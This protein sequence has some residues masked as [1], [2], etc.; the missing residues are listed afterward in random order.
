[1]KVKDFPNWQKVVFNDRTILKADVKYMSWEQIQA[2]DNMEVL[3][4]EDKGKVL[5]IENR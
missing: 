4:A 5:I 3:I 1:M 2:L